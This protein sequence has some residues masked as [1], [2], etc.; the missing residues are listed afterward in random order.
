MVENAAGFLVATPVEIIQPD[1]ATDPAG[2]DQLRTAVARTIGADLASVFG[3]ALRVRANPRIN[4]A[5]VDQIV[6]P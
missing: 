3:E 4:Q 2:Y 5:N 1:P 6:Q